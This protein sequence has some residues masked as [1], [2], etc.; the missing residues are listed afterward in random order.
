MVVQWVRPRAS[1]A[2]G[3]GSIPG[4]GMKIPHAAHRGQKKNKTNEHVHKDICTKMLIMAFV[5][6]K[7]WRTDCKRARKDEGKIKGLIQFR[8]KD[9]LNYDSCTKDR[10]K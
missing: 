4:R 2:G 8:Q 10:N 3:A 1:T 7:V 6:S 5:H 9:S